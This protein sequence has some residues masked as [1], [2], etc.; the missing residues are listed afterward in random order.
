MIANQPLTATRSRHFFRAKGGQPEN[1][2]LRMERPRGFADLT[3][4]QWA[5]LVTDRLRTAEAEHRQRRAE[6]GRQVLGREAV[7]AQDPLRSP[8]GEA[9]HFNLNPRVAAKRK[10]ERIQALRRNDGF[11][12][13]YR[14]AFDSFR[15]GVANVLFPFGT[16]RMRI[17]A[18]VACETVELAE[19]ALP[20]SDAAPA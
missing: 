15:E 6:A 11:V 1:V 14:A 17:F 18:R 10:G 7:L 13:R 4:D 2:T 8:A 19:R 5:K 3:H 16:W 20:L 12:A 9:S